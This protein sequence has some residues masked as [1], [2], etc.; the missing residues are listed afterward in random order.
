[1]RRVHWNGKY[2]TL[3]RVQCDTR[4]SCR[5]PLVRHCELIKGFEFGTFLFSVCRHNSH[6][7]LNNAQDGILL[8]VGYSADMTVKK[9]PKLISACLLLMVVLIISNRQLCNVMQP[10][11]LFNTNKTMIQSRHVE[12]VYSNMM[13][14]ST[15]FHIASLAAK[16]ENAHNSPLVS[17]KPISDVAF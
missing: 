16:A 17:K 7:W 4:A 6:L 5:S 14:D 9:K 8:P 12:T 13:K 3:A 1:M 10:N 11:T 15:L 2:H